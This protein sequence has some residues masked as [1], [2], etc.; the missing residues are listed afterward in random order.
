MTLV[1]ADSSD[2]RRNTCYINICRLESRD[3]ESAVNLTFSTLPQKETD[4][5]R[6]KKGTENRRNVTIVAMGSKVA[7]SRL[8]VTNHNNQLWDVTNLSKTVGGIFKIGITSERS[9][10]SI[11]WDVCD[12]GKT[13]SADQ[14]RK[15]E[16]LN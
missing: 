6:A 12:L 9:A 11:R 2:E 8:L 3:E 13:K 1:P 7:V 15:V 4:A 10:L 16:C 14:V 5:F